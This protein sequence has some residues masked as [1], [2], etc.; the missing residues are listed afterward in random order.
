M[1]YSLSFINFNLF[2]SKKI[3]SIHFIELQLIKNK[4]YIF[5]KSIDEN[6][7]EYIKKEIGI[8]DFKI[9]SDYLIIFRFIKIE[10]FYY[11]IVSFIM[12]DEFKFRNFEFPSLEEYKENPYLIMNRHFNYIH[13]NTLQDSNFLISRNKKN[14]CCL[15]HGLKEIIQIQDMNNVNDG[16]QFCQTCL[17]N[18]IN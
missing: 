9:K 11:N 17:K 12:K 15:C 10:S 3:E 6:T 18:L 14:Y 16:I 7:I 13:V 8:Y 2:C 1:K 4:G 5:L